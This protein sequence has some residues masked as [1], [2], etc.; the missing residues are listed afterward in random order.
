VDN[1]SNVLKECRIAAKKLKSDN[2]LLNV[3]HPAEAMW[4]GGYEDTPDR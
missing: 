1:G 2:S 3:D 4:I